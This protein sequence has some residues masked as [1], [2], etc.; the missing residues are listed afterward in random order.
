MENKKFDTIRYDF[1]Q[2][3]LR[4]KRRLLYSFLYRYFT[5][6][7]LVKLTTYYSAILLDLVVIG[8]ILGLL[9]TIEFLCELSGYQVLTAYS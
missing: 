2:P 6:S 9:P 7:A 1:F 4:I 5:L 3:D 8:V